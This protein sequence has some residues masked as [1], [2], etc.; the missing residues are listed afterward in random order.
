MFVF[1]TGCPQKTHDVYFNLALRD[2]RAYSNHEAVDV[3]VA[4]DTFETSD[5]YFERV[6]EDYREVTRTSDKEM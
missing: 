4:D 3:R 1:Y 2:L 6:E 5:T